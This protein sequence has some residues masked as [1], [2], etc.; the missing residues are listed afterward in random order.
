MH[1]CKLFFFSISARVL[2][3]YFSVNVINLLL[4]KEKKEKISLLRNELE[5]KTRIKN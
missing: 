5:H 3:R 4:R 2:N 1:V